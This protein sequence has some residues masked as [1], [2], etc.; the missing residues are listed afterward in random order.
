MFCDEELG[1]LPAVE[2]PTGDYFAAT[3]RPRA[4]GEALSLSI[5]RPASASAFRSSP[6]IGTGYPSRRSWP[7]STWRS[8]IK[9]SR[10]PATGVPDS[11]RETGNPV[12]PIEGDPSRRRLPGEC[13]ATQPFVRAP[14]Y[15]RHDVSIAYLIDFTMLRPRRSAVRATI[16]PIS[17][18]VAHV[19]GRW[20]RGC[21]VRDRRADWPAGAS[22]E[23]NSSLHLP[24]T[25][26]TPSPLVNDPRSTLL[27]DGRARDPNAPR[28]R[29]RFAEPVA[30]SA[31]PWRRLKDGAGVTVQGLPLLSPDCRLTA[32][33]LTSGNRLADPHG[34]RPDNTAISRAQGPDI[35]LPVGR[36]GGSARWD[37]TLPCLKR[38]EKE[39]TARSFL[40]TPNA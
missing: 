7:T 17:A 18:A 29:P 25:S 39:K 36:T 22:S 9:A 40:S 35:P 20:R 21:A 26:S 4:F 1:C 8:S 2:L 32:I 15:A 33:D 14:A 16:R 19:G 38:Y 6:R 11:H 5:S 28:P 23:T 31:G 3:S 34:E 10:R 37:Q 13:T 27:R 30:P 24:F 12:C